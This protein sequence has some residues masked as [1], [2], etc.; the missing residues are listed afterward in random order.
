MAVRCQKYNNKSINVQ[1]LSFKM[2][3][4]ILSIEY[5]LNTLIKSWNNA[6]VLF[7]VLD[8]I[9]ISQRD[10]E[11][12]GVREVLRLKPIPWERRLCPSTLPKATLI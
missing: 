6:G 9:K 12:R 10:W 4:E 3:S 1:L 11:K 8:L 7:L 2:D 5:R